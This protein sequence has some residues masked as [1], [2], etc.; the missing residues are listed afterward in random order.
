MQG[1]REREYGVPASAYAGVREVAREP[2]PQMVRTKQN[3]F[4]P[5]SRTAE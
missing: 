5:D 2:L 1:A 4:E 3:H